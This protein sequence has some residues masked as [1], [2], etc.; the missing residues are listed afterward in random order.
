M[1]QVKGQEAADLITALQNNVAL[2]NDLA[3]EQKN[4]SRQLFEGR[5]SVKT[6]LSSL[7]EETQLKAP[8]IATRLSLFIT[9]GLLNDGEEKLVL[10]ALQ[11]IGLDESIQTQSS[12]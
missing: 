11:S 4:L 12:H 6:S 3:H 8:E 5:Q 2:R 10:E 7:Y 1:D 9:H